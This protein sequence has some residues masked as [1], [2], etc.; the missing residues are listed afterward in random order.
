MNIDVGN[1]SANEMLIG[2]EFPNRKMFQ[3][4]VTKFAIYGNFTLKPLKTNM[5]RVMTCRKDQDCPW[6]IHASIVE[7][8]PQFKVRTYNL[9]HRCSRPM[10]GMAH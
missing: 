10:M 1:N 4:T 9:N 2:C 7:S 8:G 5:T 3:D 6:R